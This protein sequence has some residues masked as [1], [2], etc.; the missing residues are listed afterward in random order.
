MS[1]E[2]F[3]IQLDALEE[4][5]G[6]LAV[7]GDLKKLKTKVDDFLQNSTAWQVGAS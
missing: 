6:E 7:Q 3:C 4:E 5:V 1:V 2:H